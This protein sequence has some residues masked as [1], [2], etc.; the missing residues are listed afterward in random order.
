MEPTTNNDS[1]MTDTSN[2]SNDPQNT[3]NTNNTDIVEHKQ[4]VIY[5][6]TIIIETNEPLQGIANIPI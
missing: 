2:D 3:N 4:E 1:K 6:P 5:H